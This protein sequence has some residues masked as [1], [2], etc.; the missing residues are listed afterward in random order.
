MHST[1]KVTRHFSSRKHSENVE[2]GLRLVQKK[3]SKRITRS[4]P[5][6]VASAFATH[7]LSVVLTF[8]G[9]H[10]GILYC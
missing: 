1:I 2:E 8:N 10:T 6:D 5:S 7:P 9:S 3:S 4:I